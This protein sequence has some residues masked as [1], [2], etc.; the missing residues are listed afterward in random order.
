MYL[1]KKIM[2]HMNRITLSL[3]LLSSTLNFISC[4]KDDISNEKDKNT[5]IENTAE[6]NS[7]LVVENNILKGI[8]DKKISKIVLPSNIKEIANNVFE[9]SNI[10]EIT[11]NEGIET[12]GD[13][14]FLNS[15]IKNINFPSSLKHIGKAAFQDCTQLEKVDLSKTAVEILSEGLFFDSGLKEISLPSN[16][17]EISNEVFCGTNNLHNIQIGESTVIIGNK[18]FYQS[19]LTDITLHN[20]YLLIDHMA[21]GNCINLKNVN[22]VSDTGKNEGV[23][24]SGAFYECTSLTEVTLPDNITTLEGYTFIGCEKLQKISLPKSLKSIGDQGLRTNHDVQTIIF[25]S[26]DIPDMHNIHDTTI[27]NVL[28]FVKNINEILVPQQSVEEYKNRLSSYANKIKG[29]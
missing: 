2:K 20:N 9:G 26:S 22:K 16:L 15:Q 1:C 18:A 7:L 23:I 14:C 8:T 13:A 6:N 28:P 27:P 10:T 4:K 11:L 21:F 3:L 24:S 29:I 17:K 5:N 19:G 25:N 12:I